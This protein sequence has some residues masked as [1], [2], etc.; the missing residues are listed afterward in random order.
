[1]W[2]GEVERDRL[3]DAMTTPL[4]ARHPAEGAQAFIRRLRAWSSQAGG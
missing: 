3:A 2:R 4:G 1:M